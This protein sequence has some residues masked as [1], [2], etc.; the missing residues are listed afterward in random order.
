MKKMMRRALIGF[1]VTA[2]GLIVYTIWD[3]NRLMVV[4]QSVVIEGLPTELEGFSIVQLTDLHEKEFGVNQKR[5]IKKINKINY[6]AI[7]FTGDMMDDTQ[8][9]NYQA[10]YTILQG[11]H[12][13][14]NAWFVPGNSDPESYRVTSTVTKSEFVQGMEERGVQLLESV[15]TVKIDKA[16]IHFINF[17]LSLIRNPEKLLVV[18]GVVRPDYAYT[19]NYLNYRKRLWEEVLDSNALNQEDVLIALNHYPVVD[20]RI[21]QLQAD[22]EVV[23]RDY[24]LIMAGHYHGGQI[25]LPFLGALFVPESWYENN[26]LFPPPNRVSGLWE[27]KGVKQYVSTGLGSSDTISFLK[28]RFNNPP[29]INVLTLKTKQ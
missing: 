17:E 20:A 10:F 6:D 11:L 7:V 1:F 4:E 22:T 15:D 25:R 2:A 12:N 19:S 23:F 13:K 5:L 27:Y 26:G 14:Q 24:D 16:N 9:T 8:S 28:F 18:D 3:N 29:Q 21:D